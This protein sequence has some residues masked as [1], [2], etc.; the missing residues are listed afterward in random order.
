MAS[1]STQPKQAAQRGRPEVSEPMRRVLVTA[2]LPR[3]LTEWIASQPESAGSVIESALLKAH[4]LRPPKG[5]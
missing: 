4:K 1:N 2:R 5:Q 3:W